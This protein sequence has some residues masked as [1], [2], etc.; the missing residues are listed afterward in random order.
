MRPRSGVL[1]F[2]TVLP[3]LAAAACGPAPSSDLPVSVA[4]AVAAL[5]QQCSEVGG[6]PDTSGAIK[7]A[8]LNGDTREDF[9]LY[10]GWINCENAASIYGDREKGLGVFATDASG[11]V[12][13]AFG[14]L[15]YDAT[16]ESAGSG[17]GSELWLTTSAESCG[18]P[19]AE[20]FAE[21]SFCDRRIDWNPAAA[22]FDWAPVSTVRMIE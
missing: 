12:V 2:A 17:S 6:T 9:V 22:R 13:E 19:R 15:V 16:I 8:D 7:R 18:K 1:R 4:G 14:D 5:A 11:E 3:F 20:V 10:A 21:E